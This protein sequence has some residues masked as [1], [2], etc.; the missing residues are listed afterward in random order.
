VSFAPLALAC[1]AARGLPAGTGPR[2]ICE[3]IARREPTVQTAA[4]RWEDGRLELAS[5]GGAVL[6]WVLRR[7]VPLPFL[8]QTSGPVKGAVVD[9][10]PGDLLL[11]ASR[12][13]SALTGPE[14]KAVAPAE[15]VLRLSRTAEEK[16][17]SAAFAELVAEMKRLGV[18]PGPGGVLV[19]AA[20]GRP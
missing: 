3:E 20:R 6:P 15:W 17:L 18:S 4:A 8:E 14:G 12:G 13:L 5:G 7:G 1:Q 11:V 16:T 10:E 19:L 2:Q 9:S